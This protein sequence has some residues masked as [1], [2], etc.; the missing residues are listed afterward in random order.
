MGRIR[1]P[2]VRA[3]VPPEDLLEIDPPRLAVPD[4]V[5]AA[6][7]ERALGSRVD[8]HDKEVVVAHECRERAVRAERVELL[9]AGRAGQPHRAGPIPRTEV[10]I[11]LMDKQRARRVRIPGPRQRGSEPL[12]VLLVDRRQLRDCRRHI[13]GGL[14]HLGPAGFRLDVPSFSIL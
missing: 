9:A 6:L 3:P 10:Q 2:P 7:R 8:V 12:R 4:H 11:V 1:A 5:R 13:A 14:E